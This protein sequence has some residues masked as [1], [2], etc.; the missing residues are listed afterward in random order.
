[1]KNA[2]PNKKYFKKLFFER[3]YTYKSLADRI[4]NRIN[5]ETVNKS[6]IDLFIS[7]NAELEEDELFAF[8]ELLNIPLTNLVLRNEFMKLYK[9]D[10]E[11]YFK[12]S[13]VICSHKKYYGKQ[14]KDIVKSMKSNK[15]EKDKIEKLYYDITDISEKTYT[16]FMVTT[17]NTL[18]KEYVNISKPPDINIICSLSLVSNYLYK[19]NEGKP[20]IHE[21]VKDYISTGGTIKEIHICYYDMN[22]YIYSNHKEIKTKLKNGIIVYILKTDFSQYNMVYLLDE[23]ITLGWVG[24]IN[25]DGILFDYK[26]TTDKYEL[27]EIYNIY[28]NILKNERLIKLELDDND[29]IVAIF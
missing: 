20:Q 29:K 14:I 7:G 21:K 11:C 10:Y 9:N 1:M 16:N 8:S 24:Y 19:N 2:F 22:E 17:Y 15:I 28:E 6:K 18:L 23:N 5:K 3:K 12:A 27:L 26:I 25:L 13:I 4:N